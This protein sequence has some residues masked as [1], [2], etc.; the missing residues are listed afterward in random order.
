MSSVLLSSRNFKLRTRMLKV[1]IPYPAPTTD[2]FA[3]GLASNSHLY[4]TTSLR[5]FGSNRM[6]ILCR[7]E[8]N[9]ARYEHT[10]PNTP[11]ANKRSE[12]TRTPMD[13]GV[14]G[15]RWAGWGE[16]HPFNTQIAPQGI[17]T[18]STDSPR[19]THT[20][21]P[22]FD[23]NTLGSDELIGT[24]YRPSYNQYAL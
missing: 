22:V 4:A 12:R 5:W 6:S 21:V 3:L 11:S 23:A 16:A 18:V 24:G 15:I 17:S 8:V 9:H 1:R 14:C 2:G 10:A 13:P 19:P 7:A 20:N